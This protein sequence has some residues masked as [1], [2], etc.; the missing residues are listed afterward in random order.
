MEEEWGQQRACNSGNHKRAPE[1]IKKD[2]RVLKE[3][4]RYQ[5]TVGY[6]KKHPVRKNKL[7]F[8]LLPASPLSSPS[9]FT[10]NTKQVLVSQ[11]SYI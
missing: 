9:L 6:L 5:N 2:G 11:V 4:G 10:S 7:V 8:L 1:V 3:G